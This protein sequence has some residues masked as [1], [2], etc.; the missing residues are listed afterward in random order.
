MHGVHLPL[1]II[2]RFS[3]LNIPRGRVFTV[4]AS[5]FAF[6]S[7]SRCFSLFVQ[8]LSTECRRSR[9]RQQFPLLD[10]ARPFTRS[11]YVAGK[12]TFGRI[13]I[14]DHLRPPAALRG[15]IEPGRMGLVPRQIRASARPCS[16]AVVVVLC[17]ALLGVALSAGAWKIAARFDPGRLLRRGIRCGSTRFFVPAT[18]GHQSFFHNQ[19]I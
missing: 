15:P 8:E 7:L 18:A 1:R 14:V 13:A 19:F 4:D 2:F 9:L 3:H 6:F 11:E 10:M 12:M 5:L 17:T 16:S